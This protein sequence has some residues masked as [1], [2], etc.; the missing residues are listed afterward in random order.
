[1]FRISN[2]IIIRGVGLVVI[3]ELM[4]CI[5]TKCP[6]PFPISD[7]FWY[8]PRNFFLIVASVF[9]KFIG[10]FFA[11]RYRGDDMQQHPP[12]H[13]CFLWYWGQQ[14]YFHGPCYGPIEKCL[15]FI[16]TYPY[17][18]GE[19]WRY[20]KWTVYD[21]VVKNGIPPPKLLCFHWR[22]HWPC[23]RQIHCRN[24]PVLI[25]VLIPLPILPRSHRGWW[26]PPSHPTLFLSPLCPS[27][28]IQRGIY[29]LIGTIV[30]TNYIMGFLGMPKILLRGSKNPHPRQCF[31]QGFFV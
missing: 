5:G 24:V 22:W 29:L 30:T 27:Y 6:S 21:L 15:S 20:Q 4:S 17:A 9:T 12:H 1:M 23:S 28:I 2:S 25:T 11:I 8:C 7:L 19:S 14:S 3:T 10:I 31:R 18:V 16:Y 26:Y 13:C